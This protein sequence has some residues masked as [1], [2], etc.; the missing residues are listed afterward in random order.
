MYVKSWFAFDVSS[1]LP[2]DY[3]SDMLPEEPAVNY[4]SRS[5]QVIPVNL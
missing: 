1:V 5:G 3:I 4:I 2:I